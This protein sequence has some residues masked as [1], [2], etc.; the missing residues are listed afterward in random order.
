M[1]ISPKVY[2]YFNYL[3]Q[4]LS[5][6]LQKYTNLDLNSDQFKAEI[7][8]IEKLLAEFLARFSEEQLKKLKQ[9][10]GKIN[11]HIHYVK[12]AI[13]QY[14][15]NKKLEDGEVLASVSPIEDFD[16]IK[17]SQLSAMDKKKD[18]KRWAEFT[19]KSLKRALSTKSIKDKPKRIPKKVKIYVK[20]YHEK[21]MQNEIEE[22][23]FKTKIRVCITRYIKGRYGK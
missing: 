7:T 22:T 18:F 6:R 12:S 23:P 14:D 4:Q 19:K 11:Q 20:K 8:H 15:S 10:I 9:P 1:Q 5:D 16:E 13:S 3:F 17:P 21:F 2:Q